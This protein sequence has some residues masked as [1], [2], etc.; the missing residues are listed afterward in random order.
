MP[1]LHR[2]CRA[3][4]LDAVEAQL[5]E[6]ADAT[7]LDGA[8]WSPLL[9]AAESGSVPIVAALLKANVDASVQTRA[10]SGV[11]HLLVKY[12]LST[13]QAVN[14]ATYVKLLRQLIERGASM[15]ANADGETPLH[16]ATRA[17]NVAALETLLR[18]TRVDVDAKSTQLQWT[19]LHV[20]A[21]A[22]ATDAAALLIRHGANIHALGRASR[23]APPDAP[24]VTPLQVER[25]V[26]AVA[27]WCAVC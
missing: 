12:G 19:A 24:L 8:G 11:L 17:A 9:H 25:V 1:A 18:D 14:K 3:G 15:A 22:G 16:V 4:L 21:R 26:V 6:G 27:L 7:Q 5:N 20:A 10:G 2:A 13:R 23:E